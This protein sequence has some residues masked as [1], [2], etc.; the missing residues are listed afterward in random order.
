VWYQASTNQTQMDTIVPVLFGGALVLAIATIGI[1]A[2][3]VRITWQLIIII[4]PFILDLLLLPS[5]QKISII[6]YQGNYQSISK[7]SMHVHLFI[8]ESRLAKNNS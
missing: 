6:F 3:M 7:Q 5:K 8:F 2:V 1:L 4:I